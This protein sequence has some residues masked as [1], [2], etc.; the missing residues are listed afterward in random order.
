M[1]GDPFASAEHRRRVI[2]RNSLECEQTD[3]DRYGRTVALCFVDGA[4]FSCARCKPTSPW[5]DTAL[6][7]AADDYRNWNLAP[8][9]L[10]PLGD[11]ST[12]QKSVADIRIS[13]DLTDV[14]P[15][16]TRGVGRRSAKHNRANA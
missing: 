12:T 11:P 14:N 9:C 8:A 13:V 15:L 6:Y 3:T 7:R 1:D 4:N 2:G 10:A 5:F 16:L